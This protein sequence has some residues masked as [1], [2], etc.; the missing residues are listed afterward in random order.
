[1]RIAVTQRVSVDPRT[2]E[3]RDALDQRWPAFLHEAGYLALPV[4][5]DEAILPAFLD[6][7]RPAGVLLTGGNDL[8][9]LGGDAPERDAVEHALIRYALAHDMP[10][11]GVCRGM[12][13]IQAHYG[14]TCQRVEGHVAACQSIQFEEQRIAVNSYHGFGT[15]QTAPG[16]TICGRA[17][18]GTV[19]A[20]RADGAR[21]LGVMWH[22]ERIDPV[23]PDD[24][25]LFRT[26][27]GV[28]E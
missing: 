18:D 12:Q 10:L 23:R 25:T 15:S 26:F 4:P 7:I 16:L 27:F 28:S 6:D 17:D 13:M 11:L 2:A 22:P 20:V 19:K 14:V 3:R 21:V 9:S 8:A 5:N 24:L 1:M